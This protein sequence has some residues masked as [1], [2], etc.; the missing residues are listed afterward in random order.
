M[1]KIIMI[2]YYLGWTVCGGVWIWQNVKKLNNVSDKK[3]I[4]VTVGLSD[5]KG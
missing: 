5:P 2:Y 4:I 3:I 1:N